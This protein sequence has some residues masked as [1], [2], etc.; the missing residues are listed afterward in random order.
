VRF[1]RRAKKAIKT[2]MQRATRGRIVW[3]GPAEPRRVALTFDDGPHELT[4]RTLDLLAELDVAATFFVM[5]TW[6]ENKPALVADYLRG[7]HQLA[8]HGYYHKEFTTLGA[9]GLREEL[10]K[11]SSA[12]GPLPHGAWVRP[13]HGTVGAIDV[14]TMIAS[15]YTVALW[16][17][18]SR[19]HDGSPAETIADRCRPEHVGPGEVILLHEGEETTLAALPTIIERLRGD[20]YELVTMADMFAR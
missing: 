8:G 19:D 20:G 18:D 11:M 2:V 10:A 17:L 7:G 13:P 12:L 14:T 5:G 3:R 6:M 9:R 16:S 1:P 4:R 15:G